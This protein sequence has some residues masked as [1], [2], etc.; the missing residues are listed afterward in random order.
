MKFIVLN[1]RGSGAHVA[2]VIGGATFE[3]KVVHEGSFDSPADSHDL[4]TFVIMR[5]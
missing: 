4:D 2:D 3:F 1:N 5:P